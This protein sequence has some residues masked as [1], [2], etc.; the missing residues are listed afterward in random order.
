MKLS[1]GQ[2]I[3]G[4]SLVHRLDPRVKIIM[5]VLLILSSILASRLAAIAMLFIAVAAVLFSI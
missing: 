1:I 2:F 3:P 4:V 5:A